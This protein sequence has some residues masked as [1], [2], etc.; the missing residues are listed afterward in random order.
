[1]NADFA[2]LLAIDISNLIESSSG[3][4]QIQGEFAICLR[5]FPIQW[6]WMKQQIL[7]VFSSRVRSF[8]SFY[9]VLLFCFN[10]FYLYFSIAFYTLSFN[11]SDDRIFLRDWTSYFLGTFWSSRRSNKLTWASSCVWTWSLAVSVWPTF[12]RC[13]D[14]SQTKDKN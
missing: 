11:S 8:N 5:Q 9:K 4:L 7:L 12:R 14:S 1:M 13:H 3:D 2:Q 6:W 10:S